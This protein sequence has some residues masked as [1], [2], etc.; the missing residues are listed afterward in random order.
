MSDFKRYRK[1]DIIAIVETRVTQFAFG[2]GR[3]AE[4]SHNIRIVRVESTSRDGKAVKKYRAYPGSPVYAYEN[5]YGRFM[6]MTIQ[7]GTTQDAARRLFDSAKY[8]L[9]FDTQDAAKAAITA[10]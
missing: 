9:D 2:S 1:G 4:T 7:S 6:L 5:R 3:P 8:F 10:A